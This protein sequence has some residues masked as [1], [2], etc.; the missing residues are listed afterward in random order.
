L[1]QIEL[2]QVEDYASRKSISVD[3]AEKF[4]FPSLNYKD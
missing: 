3:E 2:D 4:L 1:G